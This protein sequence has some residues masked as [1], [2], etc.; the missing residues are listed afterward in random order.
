MDCGILSAMTV[1]VVGWKVQLFNL[2][3]III[4]FLCDFVYQFYQNRLCSVAQPIVSLTGDAGIASS[5]PSLSHLTFVEIA[6]DISSIVIL[7][8]LVI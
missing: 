7:P 1:S 4:I 3:Q 5:N 8:L 6:H 2:F